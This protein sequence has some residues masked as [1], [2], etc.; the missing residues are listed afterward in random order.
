[1]EE[2]LSYKHRNM[3]HRRSLEPD[4]NAPAI[5]EPFTDLNASS[6]LV[7]PATRFAPPHNTIS[8]FISA[9]NLVFCDGNLYQ[10]WRNECCTF[11]LKLPGGGRHRVLDNEVFVLRYYPGREPSWDAVTDLGGYSMFVGKNNA[12]SMYAEGVQGLKGNCIYWIGGR[13]GDQG[14]VFDMRTRRSKPC[15]PKGWRSATCWYFHG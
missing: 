4:L 10:I 9:K 6:L 12:V 3:L 15:L 13:G 8:G 7:D 5:V 14:M 1:L 11:H 2:K